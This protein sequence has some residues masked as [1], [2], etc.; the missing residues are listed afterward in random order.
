MSGADP[1]PP[2]ITYP[3]SLFL[4]Y[5]AGSWAVAYGPKVTGSDPAGHINAVIERAG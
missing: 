3:G 5:R 1:V 2:Y 4:R